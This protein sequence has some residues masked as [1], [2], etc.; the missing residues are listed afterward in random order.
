MISVTELLNRILNHGE[1]CDCAFHQDPLDQDGSDS[2]DDSGKRDKS[3]QK[4]KKDKSKQD[5]SKKDKEKS[6]DSQKDNKEKSQ[7]SNKDK[8]DQDSEKEESQDTQDSLESNDQES[9]SSQDSDSP[10]EDSNESTDSEDSNDQSDSSEN[11]SDNSQND[12]L[13]NDQTQAKTLNEILKEFN[14]SFQEAYDKRQEF[15]ES[16]TKDLQDEIDNV[17]LSKEIAKLLQE[18]NLRKHQTDNILDTIK[19]KQFNFSYHPEGGN[20]YDERLIKNMLN[21]KTL[22]KLARS[23]ENMIDF[24]C[25]NGIFL[26]K[27]YDYKKLIVG[28]KTKNINLNKCR[29]EEMRKKRLLLLC[30]ISGSCSHTCM[31]LAA[32]CYKIASRDDR[33]VILFHSNLS[34]QLL[35]GNDI[36]KNVLSLINL[37]YNNVHNREKYEENIKDFINYLSIKLMIGFGDDHGTNLYN[38]IAKTTERSFLLSHNYNQIWGLTKEVKAYYNVNTPE[39][40][41]GIFE[42]YILRKREQ[43]YV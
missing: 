13:P 6:K 7:D 38:A 34:P 24:E 20:F 21:N 12:Q 2:K 4:P 15:L 9:T 39:D 1:G 17:K 29:K 18:D 5:K 35:V 42:N 30:D 28:L 43:L 23:V 11:D 33:V 10:G 41:V 8:S 26:S 40:V 14:K 25:G 37:S 22:D 16:R 32:A 36:D 3:K 19:N 31:A 27:K